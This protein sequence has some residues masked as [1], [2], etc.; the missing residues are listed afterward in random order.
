MRLSGVLLVLDMKYN[1]IA[2]GKLNYR[3]RFDY[4]QYSI[5]DKRGKMIV[6]VQIKREVY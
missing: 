1:L 5:S 3:V 4:G 6:K 2:V